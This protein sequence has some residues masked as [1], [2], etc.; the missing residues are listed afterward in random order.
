MPTL[1]Q[2]EHAY[3]VLEVMLAAVRSSEEGQAIEITSDFPAPD[4][5]RLASEASSARQQHDPG[6]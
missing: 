5:S 6:S 4:Y 2:P 1:T 3:H